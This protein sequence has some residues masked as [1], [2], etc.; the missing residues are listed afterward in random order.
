MVQA[1][2][3]SCID[4]NIVLGGR[5][6]K[7]LPPKKQGPFKF[8][9]CHARH[10]H[11][12][13]YR[14]VTRA[15][16]RVF[17]RAFCR[18]SATST[19]SVSALSGAEWRLCSKIQVR[20]HLR[21]KYR[22]LRL[23]V[24]VGFELHDRHSIP[25]LPQLHNRRRHEKLR[26]AHSASPS[27]P[28]QPHRACSTHDAKGCTQAVPLQGAGLLLFWSA[29]VSALGEAA[30]LSPFN[31]LSL[32]PVPKLGRE[33]SVGLGRKSCDLTVSPMED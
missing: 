15:S 16:L 10:P 22:H 1:T 19:L 33:R 31:Q 23:S 3:P 6:Q 29:R 26:I 8:P 12:W 18:Y 7:P 9:W 4:T 14:D 30:I 11:W 32:S 13:R 25:K 20:S 27:A 2:Q 5:G 28:L 21:T 17:P 24:E